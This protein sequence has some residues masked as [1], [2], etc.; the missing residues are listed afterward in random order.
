LREGGKTIA[1]GIISN[2]LPDDEADKNLGFN[3]KSTS[4]LK[5]KDEKA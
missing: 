2:L 4:N 5:K 1:A 3:T